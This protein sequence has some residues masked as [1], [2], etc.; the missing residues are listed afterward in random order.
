MQRSN[1]DRATHA[2]VCLSGPAGAQYYKVLG[3]A[4]PS[5]LGA[6]L[7]IMAIDFEVLPA[8]GR[9]I[10]IERGELARI[11]QG[12]RQVMAEPVTIQ[13]IKEMRDSI[14]NV[15]DDPYHSNANP[16]LFHILA[17][18]KKLLTNLIERTE[19]LE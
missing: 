18:C 8:M 7:D 15:I 19:E 3:W 2:I 14:D 16:V 10:L 13:D 11:K 17:R 5:T 1:L 12:E 9:C 4:W 6:G